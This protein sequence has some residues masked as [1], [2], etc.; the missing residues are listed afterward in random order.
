MGPLS[1]LPAELLIEV[2]NFCALNDPSSP[3]TLAT[4][5]TTFRTI[6]QGT[7][8]LW[9]HIELRDDTNAIAKLQHKAALWL[10]KSQPLPFEVDLDIEQSTDNILPL[11]LPIIPHM[12]RCQRC[13]IKG[14][15]KEDNTFDC[16]GPVV[17]RI[18]KLVLAMRGGL[19]DEDEDDSLLSDAT[20]P[21]RTFYKSEFT[22]ADAVSMYVRI[23]DLPYLLS[24]L[25][26]SHLSAPGD[27]FAGIEALTL[28]TAWH[29]P[30]CLAPAHVL[31]LL[32]HFTRLRSFVFLGRI[33][34]E[35]VHAPAA[36]IPFVRLPRLTYLRLSN[37]C[38]TRLL[39]AHLAAP[40]LQDCVLES[41]NIDTDHTGGAELF[42]ADYAAHKD[43]A[44]DEEGA[45]IPDDPSQSPW[46]D[47]STGRGL[48]A[49]W[50]NEPFG[51]LRIL[52]M[53]YADMR[54]RDFWFMFSRLD[55]LETFKLVASDM[56]D[57]VFRWLGP[58]NGSDSTA[59]DDAGDGD[60]I[61]GDVKLPEEPAH[62]I[63]LPS[64]QTLNLIRCNRLS[65]DVILDVL[66]GRMMHC[67]HLQ[68]DNS[69]D[70]PLESWRTAPRT[71]ADID[72]AEIAS[73]DPVL[74]GARLRSRLTAAGF[75]LG[76]GPGRVRVMC[77]DWGQ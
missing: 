27:A 63:F 70:A 28:G 58:R 49:L 65:A 19:V 59:E 17:T 67:R 42:A 51:A 34:P 32:R 21:L 39:V 40:A 37:I 64:L 30:G 56:S 46:S 61:E 22:D 33:D 26:I 3:P 7:P 76:D 77:S 23:L 38:S 47:W 13:S 72:I 71:L 50:A 53:D 8:S 48:R 1:E 10:R 41:L 68:L 16:T 44:A 60:T 20:L 35:I 4:I 12:H 75:L 31:Q 11:L 5:N 43:E 15:R 74:D 18:G 55:R 57:R 25:P 29:M 52:E 62:A 69:R 54:S 24:H 66:V 9:C 73:F 36:D 45:Q 6:V 2:L 14:R